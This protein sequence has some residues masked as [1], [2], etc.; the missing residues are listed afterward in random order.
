MD[1]PNRLQTDFLFR[2]ICH[3]SPSED[4]S[5]KNWSWLDI[6]MCGL[7]CRMA[8]SWPK[9]RMRSRCVQCWHQLSRESVGT[10][11]T[12][13]D[14][15]HVQLHIP[16]NTCRSRLVAGSWQ[17][18]HDPPLVGERFF[19]GETQFYHWAAN[20]FKVPVC[21]HNPWLFESC[22]W[23]SVPSNWHTSTL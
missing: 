5:W 2:R 17:D 8:L 14:F 4:F 3:C 13:G 7:C 1:D 10:W 15:R 20:V 18:R 11:R 12:W 19:L 16:S 22:R 23:L 6:T 21:R 9:V